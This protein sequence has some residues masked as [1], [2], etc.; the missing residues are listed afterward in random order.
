M[1]RTHLKGL[2]HPKGIYGSVF[3]ILND[4]CCCIWQVF[5]LAGSDLC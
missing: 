2:I 1:L 5:K 4:Y 3:P